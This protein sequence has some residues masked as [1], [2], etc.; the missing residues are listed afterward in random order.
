L[1][2]DFL[3]IQTIFKFQNTFLSLLKKD[4]SDQYIIYTLA[5]Y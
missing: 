4:W 2:H 1:I 5:L 3:K